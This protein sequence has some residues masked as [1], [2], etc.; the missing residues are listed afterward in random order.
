MGR[1]NPDL[2]TFEP[3]KEHAGGHAPF[4]VR[5]ELAAV[6]RELAKEREENRKLRKKL[7]L[8]EHWVPVRR[9]SRNIDS[10]ESR[11]IA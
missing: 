4:C 1:M 2:E 3:C 10:A 9:Q 6:K 7:D 11:E 8:A 5:C